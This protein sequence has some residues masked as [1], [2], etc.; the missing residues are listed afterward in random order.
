MSLKDYGVNENDLLEIANRALNDG[1]IIV[2]KKRVL[3]DDIINILRN[4]L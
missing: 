2:N 1:A 4:A 3:K